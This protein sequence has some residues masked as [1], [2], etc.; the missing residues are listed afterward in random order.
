[1]FLVQLIRS[2][3]HSYGTDAHSCG[4]LCAASTGGPLAGPD[5]RRA[6]QIAF[7]DGTT[8]TVPAI[9]IRR[10]QLARGGGSLWAMGA[11]PSH[12][13][14]GNDSEDEMRVTMFVADDELGSGRQRQRLGGG[15]RAHGAFLRFTQAG[16]GTLG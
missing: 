2:T 8:E 10:R 9:L 7:G 11:P 16:G 12:D 1:M 5:G 6:Y 13:D 14:S 4:V 15:L 3:F